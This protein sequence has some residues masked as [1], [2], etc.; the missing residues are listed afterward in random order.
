MKKTFSAKPEDLNPQWWVI[1]A[2]DLTLGR[3]SV[4]VALLLRGKH[5]PGYTPHMACGDNVII[6]N[7]EKVKVTGNKAADKLYRHHT[8]I[9]GHLKTFTYN[10]MM[11]RNPTKIL[12]LAVWGMIPHNRLG[13]VLIRNLHVYTGAE[14][15]HQAQKPEAYTLRYAVKKAVTA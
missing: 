9:V 10:Q 8:G 4:E 13:R 1:D 11:D 6:I 3:L 14:H 5:K 12:E 15:P 2:T 7:A